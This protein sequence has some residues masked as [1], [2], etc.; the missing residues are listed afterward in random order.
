MKNK[1]SAY[2]FPKTKWLAYR[3]IRYRNFGCIR[4]RIL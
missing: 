1:I 4:Y 2:S 3:C